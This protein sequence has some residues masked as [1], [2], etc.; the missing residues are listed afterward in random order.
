MQLTLATLYVERPSLI[1]RLASSPLKA[2]TQI[3][4]TEAPAS[5]VGVVL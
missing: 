4:Q 2:G 3:Q 1:D 5:A